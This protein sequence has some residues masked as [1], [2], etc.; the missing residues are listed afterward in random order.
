MAKLVFFVGSAGVGKT[1][2]AVELAKHHPVVF[3]DKDTVGERIV[4]KSLTVLGYSP[5]DRDSDFYREHFRD[6]EYEA[7][8]DVAAENLKLGQDVFAIGP[9]TNELKD[10]DYLPNYLAE[11]GLADSNVDVKLVIVTMEQDLDEIKERIKERANPRDQWKLE[12]WEQ[13]KQRIK[14]PTTN[15]TQADILHF[16]NGSEFTDEKRRE[17]ETFIGWL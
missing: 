15:W 12:N 3:L 8:L 9:F 2:V 1:T 16:D 7:T 13:Y 10:P 6:V 4:N 11:S 17:L 14:T 5:D